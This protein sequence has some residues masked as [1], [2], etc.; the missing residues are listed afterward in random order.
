M[1]PSLKNQKVKTEILD[2]SSVKSRQNQMLRL[3]NQ[4]Y[5]VCPKSFFER[6]KSIDCYAIYTCNGQLI[7]FTGFRIK[8]VKTESGTFQTLY[9]GQTVMKKQFRGQNIIPRTC[10]SLLFKLFLKNPF[11]PVHVWCDALTYKPYLIFANSVKRFYPSRLETTSPKI[12]TLLDHLGHHYYGESYN[13]PKG[14]VRKS[15]NIIND[16]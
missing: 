12:K 3:Y 14:T 9:I 11:R 15:L 7:G 16:L 4:Y 1:E 10:C 6:F 8:E 2:S 13:A 5:K